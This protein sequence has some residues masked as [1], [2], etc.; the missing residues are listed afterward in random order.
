MIS[1]HRGGRSTIFDKHFREHIIPVMK[2]G[3]TIGIPTPSGLAIFE[4]KGVSKPK[5]SFIEFKD[6]DVNVTFKYGK[7]KPGYMGNVNGLGCDPDTI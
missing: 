3:E 1:G 5:P 2:E 6:M 7:T 4:F